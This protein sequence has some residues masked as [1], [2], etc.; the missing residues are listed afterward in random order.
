VADLA[1]RASSFGSVA[2]QYDRFRPGPPMEAVEWV[3]PHRCRTAA[4]VGAG[5][6]ALTRLLARRADRVVAVEPDTRMLDRL[7]AHPPRLPAVRAAAERLPLRSGVLDA[8]MISSAW[9]WMD[10]GPTLAEL[11]RVLRPGGRLGVLWGGIDRSVGWVTEVLG[12]GTPPPGY[13][14][15]PARPWRRHLFEL[16]PGAPFAEPERREITSTLTITP[17]Q[18]VG[19][20]GTYSQLI[21]LEAEAK[22][23]ELARVREAVGSVSGGHPVPVPFRCRCWRT[24]RL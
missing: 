14:A 16:T 17:D 2:E 12:A 20:A 3:L 7:V 1:Q 21:T 4:D 5:T 6:G 24:T 10:A 19:L 18:L 22:E 11:G 13:G 9:H 23:A 8:V 15:D